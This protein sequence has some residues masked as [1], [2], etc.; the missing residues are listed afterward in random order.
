MAQLELGE[1]TATNGLALLLSTE[2]LMFA[3]FALAANFAAPDARR[4]RNMP[5]PG[6]MIAVLA[7]SLLWVIA[8][9]AVVAW[10][11]LFVGVGLVGT[12]WLV[13]LAI[14][15]P[16]VGEPILASFLALGLRDL[17]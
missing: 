10:C 4:V 8:A 13:A 2:S 9:G 12:D 7:V 11:R 17:G 1:F 5:I 6:W 15:A 3:A 14:L 16:I